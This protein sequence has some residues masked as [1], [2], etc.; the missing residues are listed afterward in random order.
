[1]TPTRKAS[2][3][4]VALCALISVRLFAAPAAG[5]VVYLDGEVTIDGKEAAE[6]EQVGRGATVRT[7]AA[8]ICEITFGTDNII[9]VQAGTTVTL[10]LGALAP[11]LRV[12][13]RRHAGGEVRTG[14]PFP[15]HR[16]EPAEAH[17]QRAAQGL[18]LGQFPGNE[19]VR[20][21]MARRPVGAVR[22]RG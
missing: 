11:G 12:R 1:M 14:L 13:R 5:E 21:G 3:A 2:A 17:G 18:I 9:Q 7:G 20:P 19:P 22:A 4:A 8:S 15:V 10:E 6:G 16:D